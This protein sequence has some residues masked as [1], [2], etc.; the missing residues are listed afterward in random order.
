M[1]ILYNALYSVVIRLGKIS[2][3]DIMVG[4]QR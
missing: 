1:L 2:E 3:V 4:P